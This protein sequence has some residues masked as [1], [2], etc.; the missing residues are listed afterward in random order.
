MNFLANAVEL[1]SAKAGLE[2]LLGLT[3]IAAR[4]HLA[5]K[6]HLEGS[7]RCCG[8][9][10]TRTVLC[11]TIRGTCGEAD[12]T[13]I[14]GKDEDRIYEV[15]IAMNISEN[16]QTRFWRSPNPPAPVRPTCLPPGGTGRRAGGQACPPSRAAL[17]SRRAELPPHVQWPVINIQWS[18]GDGHYP[19]STI[20]DQVPLACAA[21]V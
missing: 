4:I 15:H 6:Q 1:S 5:K 17:R 3:S 2:I 14:L 18:E 13:K 11:Q 19:V 10:L 9:D 8:F 12:V 20:Q 16:Q 7:I 21:C